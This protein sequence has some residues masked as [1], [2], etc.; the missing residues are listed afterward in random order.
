[1]IGGEPNASFAKHRVPD[2]FRPGILDLSRQEMLICLEGTR[3]RVPADAGRQLPYA[4]LLGSSSAN[5]L[6]SDGNPPTRR[7]SG[8]GVAEWS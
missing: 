8:F 4:N 5:P 3:I 1:M 7:D 6:A 2:P